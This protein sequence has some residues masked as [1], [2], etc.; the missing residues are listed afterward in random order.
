[1]SFNSGKESKLTSLREKIDGIDAEIVRLLNQRARVVHEV[2]LVKGRAGTA[3][4]R[5]ERE[6]FI[7]ERAASLS[8][9]LKPE[10]IKAIFRE[11]LSG[12]RA[13]E[14]ETTV[15]YLGPEGTFSEMA[16]LRRF[17]SSVKALPCAT[18]ADVF[19]AVENGRTD[20]GVVPRENNSQGSVMLTLDMLLKT[21]LSIVGEVTVPVIHNLMSRTGDLSRVKKVLAHPQ[22]LAQCREWLSRHLPDARQEGCLSNAEAARLASLDPDVAGI[23]AR[24]AAELYGL[25]IVAE[26]IQDS[27]QNRTRFL[28]MGHDQPHKSKGGL[29]DK[30]TFV[31]VVENRAGALFEVLKL[32]AAENVDMLHLES[33]PARNGLWEYYFFV[34][35]KGHV[36]DENVKRALDAVRRSCLAFKLL[37]S[38]PVDMDSKNRVREKQQ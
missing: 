14:R 20:F 26:G 24:R 15:A 13:L 18:V 31:F 1:M 7:L 30:T 36:E 22:A 29:E 34:D 21:S 4:F 2:G 11:V 6:D 5:P 19:S 10:A 28:I 25:S 37:G 3:V 8:D 9:S 12:C 33:R 16:V 27:S 32:L 38:Y 35:A 17:G 23:A